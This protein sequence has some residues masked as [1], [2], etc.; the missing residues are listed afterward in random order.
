MNTKQISIPIENLPEVDIEDINQ[1]SRD[2]LINLKNLSDKEVEKQ[3]IQKEKQEK[4]TLESLDLSEGLRKYYERNAHI[5]HHE[6]VSDLKDTE[7]QINGRHPT[8]H[9]KTSRFVRKTIEEL[10]TKDRMHT[11]KTKDD[12]VEN[13]NLIKDMKRNEK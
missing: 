10:A 5:P 12:I 11:L 9:H 3:E 1:N 13:E 8:S 4:L 2:G 7:E 6:L